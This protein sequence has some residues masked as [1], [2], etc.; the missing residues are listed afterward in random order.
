MFCHA[1]YSG[2]GGAVFCPTNTAEHPQ[3]NRFF[4]LKDIRFID[5]EVLF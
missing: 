4:P 2:G 3:K 5:L 1:F